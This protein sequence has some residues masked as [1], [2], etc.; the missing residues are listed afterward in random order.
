MLTR[1]MSVLILLERAGKLLRPE[2]CDVFMY[3]GVFYGAGC[4]TIYTH[5]WSWS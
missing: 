2:E 5:E 4:Y 1:R 3:A